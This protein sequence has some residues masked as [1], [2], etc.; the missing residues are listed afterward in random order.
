MRA[1]LRAATNGESLLPPT[2]LTGKIPRHLSPTV[3]L[4][5]A[6]C[7]MYAGHYAGGKEF[8]NPGKAGH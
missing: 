4:S 2:A 3:S 7:R 8:V 6:M 5:T 1:S